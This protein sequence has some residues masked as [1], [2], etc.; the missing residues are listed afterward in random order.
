M[1]AQ[2]R[3]VIGGAVLQEHQLMAALGEG[4]EE[5]EEDGADEKPVRDL[6]ADGGGAGGRGG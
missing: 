2:A 4:D 5:G 6:H 1:L 3:P